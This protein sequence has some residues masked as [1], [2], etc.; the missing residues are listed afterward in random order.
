MTNALALQHNQKKLYMKCTKHT[1]YH[2]RR[3]TDQYILVNNILRIKFCLA[4]EPTSEV[5]VRNV[6]AAY[7]YRV[8]G[9]RHE[10]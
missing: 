9:K 3:K 7:Q 10:I 4:I 6:H 2:L 5:V 8:W 1:H